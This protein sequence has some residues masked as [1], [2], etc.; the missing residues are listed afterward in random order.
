M[1]ETVPT[2]TSA[3]SQSVPLAHQGRIKIDR[4]QIDLR[5]DF[6]HLRVR[7]LKVTVG[8]DGVAREKAEDALENHAHLAALVRQ[9]AFAR[10]VVGDVV[11]VDVERAPPNE[12]AERLGNI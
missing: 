2:A 9:D 5:A 3:R 6:D 10:E 12:Q 11:E 7:D 4:S 1:S 8:V